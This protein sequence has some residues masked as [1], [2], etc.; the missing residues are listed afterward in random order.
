M[1][2]G[3]N[4]RNPHTGYRGVR[5]SFL[6]KRLCTERGAGTAAKALREWGGEGEELGECVRVIG[7]KGRSRGSA[8][9][10]AVCCV[11]CGSCRLL[12][13]G[14]GVPCG[15]KHIIVGGQSRMRRRSRECVEAPSPLPTGR[16]GG[17][18]GGGERWCLKSGELAK[19][20]P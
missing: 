5:R 6:N 9:V 11:R 16:A 19:R 10:L 14:G 13:R 3:R 8:G 20:S 18:R 1:A 12:C 15:G 17:Y 4:S 2:S 7:G